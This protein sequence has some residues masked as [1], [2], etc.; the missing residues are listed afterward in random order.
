MKFSS[1]A[2]TALLA[3]VAR[4]GCDYVAGNYYCSETNAVVYSDVGY[5]GHYSDVTS[6][7]ESSCQCS[8]SSLSFS[9]SLSPLDEELSVHFRGPINLV[10]FGVYYPG[11]SV[12]LKKRDAAAEDAPCST[13]AKKHHDHKR[14]AAI[15]WVEVTSTVVVDADGNPVTTAT[16]DVTQSA[17]TLPE[18]TTILA[19]GSSSSSSS[20]SSSDASS[21]SD[22]S[23]PSSAS[24]S[25]SASSTSD[26][27]SSSTAWNRVSYF[28][29]GSAQNLTFMNHQGGVKG[30]GIW[31]SCFGNSISF[32]D[33]DGVSGS[34]SAVAL[35]DVT[36]PSNKEFMIFSGSSCD[37]SS[38][39]DCG[40]YRSGIPA[41]HG[42]GGA[43][44]M[45][46]FEFSMPTDNT[47]DYNVD[48]PAVWLLNAK[49][50]RTLQY[51]DETCSCWKTGC[52]ELDLFEILSTGS[53]KLITHLHSGQGSDGTSS[54]GGGTQDYFSR[55]T[56][57]TLKAAVIFDG[58]D[59][60]IHVV[61]V[62]ESFDS[63]I[64]ADT[65]NSWFSVSGSSAALQ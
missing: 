21:G 4:A 14:E 52:G 34:G 44:K 28:T 38:N 36:L 55:P 26:S 6:M 8:Q 57:G 53:D 33:S 29:P 39:G 30:S 47:G 23:S 5:S 15:Q 3:A 25:A 16:T 18:S 45:F 56:S 9:G 51:G 13:V 50:P 24:S 42:F 11:E 17:S 2:S 27:G 58:S 63:T 31:S 48:M 54:G 46:V 12:N 19:P 40:Y 59:K 32:C 61:E 62:D 20:S 43:T 49:I 65:V 64:S 60:T 22:S 41:Y 7:D 37:D 35:D 1:V 10:Q